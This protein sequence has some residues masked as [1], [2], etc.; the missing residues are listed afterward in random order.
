MTGL[1]FMYPRP[2]TAVGQDKEGTPPAQMAPLLTLGNL[3]TPC[4]LH[5]YSFIR[6]LAGL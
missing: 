6:F 5:N 1:Q 3:H 2:V 4:H